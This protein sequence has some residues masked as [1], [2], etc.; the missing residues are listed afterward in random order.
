MTSD[1][2]HRAVSA[3]GTEIVG[4][5]YGQG[6][7]LVLFHGAP[8]DGDLAWESLVP[9]LADRFTCYLPSWRGRGLSSDHE[10]HTPPRHEEDATAFV[11]SIG[12]SVNVAGWSAGVMTTLSAAANGDAVVAVALY[13]PTVIPVMREDDLADLGATF[14]Q[15]GAAAAEGQLA[16]ASRA[17]HRFVANDDELAALDADYYERS[18]TAFPSLLRTVQASQTYAGPESTDPEAMAR[19][20]AP[21]LLLRGQQTRRAGFYTD[22]EQYVAKHVPDPH[23]GGLPDVG[24]FAPIVAPE[25][26]AEALVSYFGSVRQPA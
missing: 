3:D 15:I 21:V 16:D 25:P 26:V 20:S 17:F 10:D 18:A 8:H 5:V 13:E 19:I 6:P 22:T 14:Q 11:D 7:P 1:R 4:R 2:T 12:G 9:H 23:V 24:H